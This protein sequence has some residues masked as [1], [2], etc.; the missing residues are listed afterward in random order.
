MRPTRIALALIL[1][2]VGLVWFGQ[3]IGLIG[4]S[5]MTGSSFWAVAGVLLLALGGVITAVEYRTSR[6][7]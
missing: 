2:F 5:M 4:G 6:H 3:G 7:S 1:G